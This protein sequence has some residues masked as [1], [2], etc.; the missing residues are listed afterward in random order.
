MD[1]IISGSRIGVRVLDLNRTFDD[2]KKQLD[3]I[4]DDWKKS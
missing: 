2:I 1:E 3:D 4:V